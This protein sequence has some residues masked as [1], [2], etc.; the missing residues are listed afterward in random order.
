MR[1][2][3]VFLGIWG[4]E[5]TPSTAEGVVEWM[6]SQIQ[7]GKRLML[8]HNLHSTYLHLKDPH[9]AD[10]Y[11]RSDLTI[12]DGFPILAAVNRGRKREGESNLDS[13]FRCGS[14]DWLMRLD[15]LPVGTRIAVV[16]GSAESCSK[17]V[18]VLSEEFPKLVFEGWDGYSG[19]GALAASGFSALA[20]F[21]P[22]VVV[23]GMGMPYQETYLATHWDFLPNAIYATVGGAIDQISG[24]QKLAPRWLGRLRLEWAWR[25]ISDPLRLS[26]RYLVEP[27]QL[28]VLTVRN[29]HSL[30]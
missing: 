16:G 6:E 11:K 4:I 24:F 3:S 17:A 23:V 21:A 1:S 10:L 25:L 29:R 14:T 13:R 30:K 22:D 7:S 18:T 2:S 20:D 15:K 19:A 26:H 8:N 12:V 28:A 5:V 9:F 27:V